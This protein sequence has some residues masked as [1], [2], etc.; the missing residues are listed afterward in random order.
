MKIDEKILQILEHQRIVLETLQN[1]IKIIKNRQSEQGKN[2]DIQGERLNALDDK[3]DAQGWKLDILS[4]KV[5]AQRKRLE[6]INQDIIVLKQE[7]NKQGKDLVILKQGQEELKQ[8]LED[9]GKDI[10][11]IKTA[12][13]GLQQQQSGTHTT[14]EAIHA[15]LQDKATKEDLEKHEDFLV[16]NVLKRLNHH[17][18]RIEELEK[19]ANFSHKN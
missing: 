18:E 1:D 19:H 11:V 13:A 2:I 3:I 7:Q 15:G 6:N 17:G 8:K 4:N 12:L 14:I 16:M 9:Q 10:I 5:T